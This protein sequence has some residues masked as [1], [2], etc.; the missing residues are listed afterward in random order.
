MKA[1]IF[2]AGLGTRLKPLTDRMPKA[3]VPVCGRPLLSHVIGRLKAAGYDDIVINVHHYA[4]MIED[5]VRSN[6]DFGVRIRFSDERALLLDTGGGILYARPLLEGEGRFLVHNVDILSDVDFR[7]LENSVRP[8]SVATLLVSER[9]TSRYLLFDRD[10]RMTGWTNVSTGQVR[11][12]Y[13]PG[14]SSSMFSA[15]YA[16]SGIHI[17]S[18]AVFPFLEEYARRAVAGTGEQENRPDATIGPVRFSITDFYIGMCSSMT[19]RGVV[20]SSLDIVDVGKP[21]ALAEAERLVL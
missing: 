17:L 10:M 7:W 9:K 3:L 1:M 11:S 21:G 14:A 6:G 20:P 8:D 5:Y 16:F 12:P 18:D 13:P 19:V 2:A 15:K 4:D